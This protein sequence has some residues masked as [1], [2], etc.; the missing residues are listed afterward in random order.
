MIPFS[1]KVLTA[2]I[3][4]LLTTLTHIIRNSLK[5][6]YFNIGEKDGHYFLKVLQ[7]ET[8]RL[9]KLADNVEEELSNEGLSEEVIGK[10]RSAAGKARLLVSQKMQQFKGL[11]TNNITQVRYFD[12][13]GFLFLFRGRFDIQG[14][15][16]AFPTTSQD[17]Q[18]FWDMVMLQVDQVDALFKEIDTL[19]ANNWNEVHMSAIFHAA[20]FHKYVI[21]D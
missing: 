6:Y 10:I 4:F 18:G 1:L 20:A 11:C 17:L 7:N 5:W 21:P 14:E 9:L 15:G 12:L 16:E 13:V 3:R 19:K 8:N 2:S